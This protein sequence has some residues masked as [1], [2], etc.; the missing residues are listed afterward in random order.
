M[1]DLLE[2][3]KKS[4]L[5][6]SDGAINEF[7]NFEIVIAEGSLSCEELLSIYRGR[8]NHLG[9]YGSEHAK[10]L[11]LSTDEFCVNLENNQGKNCRFYTLKGKLKH[12]YKL[13][14]LV[15]ADELIGCLKIINK[16]HVTEEEWT[17]VWAS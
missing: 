13:I 16:L 12:Q 11:K 15:D 7:D 6:C 5:R 17:Q 9:K 3:L 10:Q 4:D 14:I 1:T 8:A 2:L